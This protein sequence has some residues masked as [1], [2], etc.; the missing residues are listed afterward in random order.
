VIYHSAV[1]PVWAPELVFSLAHGE[2]EFDPIRCV[3]DPLTTGVRMGFVYFFL[4]FL[5]HWVCRNHWLRTAAVVL[6]MLALLL[7]LE[8]AKPVTAALTVLVGVLGLQFVALRFGLL[9]FLAAMLPWG[10]LIFCGW[11]LDV[12]AWYATGP[13][14]G[15]AV[16][17]ALTLSAAY[18]AC[19]GWQRDRR[20][21]AAP[22]GG[23]P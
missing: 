11:T 13:N 1:G 8:V 15:I 12:R 7:S 5:C 17:L 21:P 10:W 23:R 19:G 16:M 18:T 3:A 6:A 4:T 9:A 14:L 2:Y 22:R 20:R